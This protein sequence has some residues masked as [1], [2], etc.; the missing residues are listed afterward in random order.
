MLFSTYHLPP[1]TYVPHTL[2]LLARVATPLHSTVTVMF[3]LRERL[4]LTPV[5]VTV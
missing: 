5:T 3:V 4:P 2:W 1:T